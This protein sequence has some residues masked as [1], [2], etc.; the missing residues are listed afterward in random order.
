MLPVRAPGMGRISDPSLVRGTVTDAEGARHAARGNHAHLIEI[1]AK[2]TSDRN[3]DIE[4]PVTM[5]TLSQG[6]RCPN[7][8]CGATICIV[9]GRKNGNL[10]SSDCVVECCGCHRRMKLSEWS[11]QV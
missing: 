11:V 9:Y 1:E 4:V 2:M 3:P 6:G 5:T 10:Q 7:P 8:H